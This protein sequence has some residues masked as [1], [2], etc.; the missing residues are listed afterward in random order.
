MLDRQNIYHI[1]NFF[2]SLEHIYKLPVKKRTDQIIKLNGNSLFEKQ[3]EQI[4]KI[5][6]KNY[7]KALQYVRENK[8]TDEI[9][10]L[11]VLNNGDALQYVPDNKKTHEICKLAVQNN[12][13]A[14]QYV[15]IEKLSEEII[16][17]AV[18][19]NCEHQSEQY[20]YILIKRITN[21]II[22]LVRL[23]EERITNVRNII[24]NEIIKFA[25]KNNLWSENINIIKLAIQNNSKHLALQKEK[26]TSVTDIDA[27]T[28]LQQARM[29]NKIIKLAVQNNKK[30]LIYCNNRCTIDKKTNKIIK[31][32]LKNNGYVII[33]VPIEKMS[34]EIIKLALENNINILQYIR[35]S[36][37]IITD[38]I[39]NFPIKKDGYDILQY[40]LI[41]KMLSDLITLESVDAYKNIPILI[42]I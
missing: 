38:D 23:S 32:T 17:L 18:R 12:G 4:I 29:T 21:E 7:G 27:L 6:V 8:K 11:A 1:Y 2:K 26:M 36:K 40:I 28:S 33:Y 10:K 3:I 35:L 39:I 9:C 19:K 30:H 41:E 15:P 13:D 37:N 31:L 25:L 34:D 22:K 42:H 24:E 20:G 16:K 5:A 14:L